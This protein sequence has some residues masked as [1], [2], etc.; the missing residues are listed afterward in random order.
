MDQPFPS[1]LQITSL[2]N[3][4]RIIQLNNRRNMLPFPRNWPQNPKDENGEESSNFVDTEGIL[5]SKRVIDSEGVTP[6]N[7]TNA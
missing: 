1:N 4:G 3:E 5:G 2:P 6:T 7:S